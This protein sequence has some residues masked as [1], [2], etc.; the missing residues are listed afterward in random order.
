M[1]IEDFHV[2]EECRRSLKRVG[3]ST[4]EEIVE[5]FEVYTGSCIPV[6]ARWLYYHREIISELK[7]LGLWPT[8]LDQSWSDV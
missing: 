3:F 8:M 2:S 5:F 7:R 1:R 6:N 4:V